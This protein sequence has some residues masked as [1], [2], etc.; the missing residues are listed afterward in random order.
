MDESRSKTNA[1]QFSAY[2]SGVSLP[3]DSL[4]QKIISLL[5]L[6]GR[7]R[8][9]AIARELGIS[10]TTVRKRLDRLVDENIVRIMAVP[11]PQTIGLTHS[12]IIALSCDLEQLDAIAETLSSLPE[13]RYLGYAAGANDLVMECFFYSHEHLL[14]FLTKRIAELPGVRHTETS[15]VL[16]VAK[17]SYEWE[18]PD[19][20]DGQERH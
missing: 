13:T 6:D 4:D 1:R 7:M 12:A 10:E 18:M 20:S 9:S 3:Y 5:Q 17:F 19:P 2:A 8:N 16:K 14:D 11:S 15:V